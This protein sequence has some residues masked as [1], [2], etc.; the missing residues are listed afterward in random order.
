MG[1]RKEPDCQPA[2]LATPCAGPTDGTEESDWRS[3]DRL[4]GMLVVQ[5]A[6]EAIDRWSCA[7]R[8]CIARYG[9]SG[10]GRRLE[11]RGGAQNPGHIRSI[12]RDGHRRPRQV[13]ELLSQIDLSDDL[14]PGCGTSS[15]TSS[16]TRKSCCPR[17]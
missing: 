3:L 6:D 10:P 5:L 4:G 8:V 15:T 16:P 17:K 13:D 2:E 1:H 14:S 7:P 9:R 12:G 11:S